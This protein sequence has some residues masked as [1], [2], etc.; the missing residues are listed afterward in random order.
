LNEKVGAKI[1]DKVYQEESV[2]CA[3]RFAP[4][5][6]QTVLAALADMAMGGCGKFDSPPPKVQAIQ[7][8]IR[9]C[10]YSAAADGILKLGWCKNVKSARCGK[11]AD[12][13]R[14]AYSES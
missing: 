4:N 12:C 9:S 8:N 2:S 11:V 1:F 10:D 3:K 13:V 14:Y 5:Q 7:E 6:P